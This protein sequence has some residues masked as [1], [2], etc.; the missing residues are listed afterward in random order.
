[1]KERRCNTT[2]DQVAPATLESSHAITFESLRIGGGNPLRRIAPANT[3]LSSDAARLREWTTPEPLHTR[4]RCILRSRWPAV[5]CER[6][7][8]RPH[9]AMGGSPERSLAGPRGRRRPRSCDREPTCGS[10]TLRCD[11]V[12]RG[13]RA[14]QESTSRGVSKSACADLKCDEPRLA[15][16][17]IPLVTTPGAASVGTRSRHLSMGRRSTRSTEST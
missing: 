9:L 3:P 4:R 5:A 15:R 11:R 14:G 7:A 1:M 2:R 13:P 10:V 6:R 8:S 12:G 17:W 16:S